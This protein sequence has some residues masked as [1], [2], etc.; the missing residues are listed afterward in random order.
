[1][2]HEAPGPDIPVVFS[3]NAREYFGIWIVNLL[4][5]VVTLGIYSAW[6][7]VRTKRYFLRNT[8]MDGRPFDYHATGRQILLGR[9]VVLAA[10][11]LYSVSSFYF[12]LDVILGVALLFVVPWLVNRALRFNAA[13]TSWSHVRFSFSGSYLAAFLVFLLYPFLAGL[14]LFL[15][16]P[17]AFRARQK[18][19]IA[20]HRLG[21]AS[22][23]FV[24]RIAPF[25]RALL[26]AAAWMISVLG[27]GIALFAYAGGIE[28]TLSMMDDF[29]SD[30]FGTEL[31]ILPATVVLA[32]LPLGTIYLA[33]SRNAIFAGASL[34]GG[35]RFV[36][37]VS[38]LRLV[39]IS[40]T[41][42]LAIVV[43]LGLLTPWARIRLARYLAEHSWIAPS[44]SLDSFTSAALER[45]SAIGDAYSDLE[46]FDVGAAI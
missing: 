36:S 21:H 30:T 20:G 3:G 14:T 39:A 25:Y 44:E 45:Q 23:G 29:K 46:G 6:A 41:N 34:E 18:Y 31:L 13:V 37:R 8:T 15:A 27:I 17:F 26:V 33:L 40:I 28:T 5:S 42:S 38:P 32:F 1:M 22:F 19:V 11:L 7:K 16:Y 35:H 4:L 24:S 2:A 10:I 12:P 43:S 9:L